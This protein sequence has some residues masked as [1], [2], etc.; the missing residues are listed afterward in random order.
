[1]WRML[2]LLLTLM[3]LSNSYSLML[4]KNVGITTG[5]AAILSFTQLINP[6]NAI[7]DCKSDCIKNCLIAAPKSNDYCKASCSDYCDQDDRHDGLSGSI[8]ARNGET[9]IF[10]GSIYGTVTDDRPPILLNLIG[11]DTM[12]DLMING[13]SKK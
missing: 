11:K 7:T 12:R 4:K 2:S 10:G 5:V 9:G 1:M 8:D 13:N 3:A 6:C